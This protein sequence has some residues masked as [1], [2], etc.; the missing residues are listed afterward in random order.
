MSVLL[1]SCYGNIVLNAFDIIRKLGDIQFILGPVGLYY[2]YFGGFNIYLFTQY[3]FAVV[4]H[5]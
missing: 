2:L 4:T 1:S 5:V 3:R